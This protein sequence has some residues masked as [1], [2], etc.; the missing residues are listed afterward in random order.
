MLDHVGR[1]GAMLGLCGTYVEPMLGHFRAMLGDLGLCWRLSNSN[2]KKTEF[3]NISVFLGFL[4]LESKPAWEAKKF[5]PNRSLVRLKLNF[6]SVSGLCWAIW[7]LQK[8]RVKF[9]YFTRVFW[10]LLGP[11]KS[12]LLGTNIM[13]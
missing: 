13:S 5:H 9:Y 4:S 8:T 1:L 10:G 2:L 7:R 11:I 6:V 3:Y 12:P